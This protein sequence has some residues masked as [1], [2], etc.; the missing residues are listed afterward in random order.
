[1]QSKEKKKR[2][3]RKLK[4]NVLSF[5]RN[6]KMEIAREIICLTKKFDEREKSIVIETS[7]IG[8]NNY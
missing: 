5:N 2:E 4:L 6:Y 8:T 1:M 3:K 7:N